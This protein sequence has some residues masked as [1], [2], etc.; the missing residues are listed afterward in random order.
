MARPATRLF[1]RGHPNTEACSFNGKF[2]DDM[3]YAT[4]MVGAHSSTYIRLP[5]N[6]MIQSCFDRVLWT[7]CHVSVIPAF[8]L[9]IITAGNK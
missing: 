7:P 4:P 2:A 1:A 6:I 8:F 3:L 9:L 5:G